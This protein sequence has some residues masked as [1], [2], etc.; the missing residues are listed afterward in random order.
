MKFID[1]KVVNGSIEVEIEAEDTIS[2]IKLW[3]PSIVLY[4]LGGELNECT[5][6]RL[7][8]SYARMLVE[9]DIIKELPNTITI[10]DKEGE[11]FQQLI[12]YKW[13]PLFCNKCQKVGH[14][15]DK[16]KP[17]MKQWMAKPKPPDEAKLPVEAKTNAGSK[18]A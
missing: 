17:P 8:V 11:N 4:A 15:C 5:A 13:R 12:E 16:L 9:M 10:R 18:N 3:E 14:Y 6:N 7:R 2:D 1:P